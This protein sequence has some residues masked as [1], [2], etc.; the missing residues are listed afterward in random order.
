MTFFHGSYFRCT[1][2]SAM[3]CGVMSFLLICDTHFKIIVFLGLLLLQTT[4]WKVI[5]YL[6]LL[7]LKW[8]SLDKETWF[9]I[10]S[11]AYANHFGLENWS[12]N[13]S[14]AMIFLGT[15]MVSGGSKILI[16]SGL[17]ITTL[18]WSQPVIA[19]IR[20]CY[21]IEKKALGCLEPQK[22]LLSHFH[23]KVGPLWHQS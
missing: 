11:K 15:Y 5:L 20:E 23:L 19:N 4:P 7:P 9:Q 18:L 21:E 16:Q 17:R 13:L 22:E 3:K 14:G 10:L 8:S 1:I 12:V 2:L 6:R